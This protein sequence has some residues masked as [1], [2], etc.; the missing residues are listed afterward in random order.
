MFGNIDIETVKIVILS[1]PR[2]LS[3][4]SSRLIYFIFSDPPIAIGDVG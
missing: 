4:E 1:F 3:G 2:T